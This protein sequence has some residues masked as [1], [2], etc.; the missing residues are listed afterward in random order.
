MIGRLVTFAVERRW[1]VL[2]FTGIA[3]LVGALALQRLPI[4]AV[5]DITNNQVQV[6]V[7]AAVAVAR[8][9]RA[10]SIVYDRNLARRY[11]WPRIHALA[12]P[13]RLCA[14]HGRI[15]RQRPI[16]TLPANRW[17]NGCVGPKNVCRKGIMPEMGPIATGLGDIFMWTVELR[18]LDKVRH[19]D[20][21]PGLQRDGSYITPEGEHLVSE[22]DKA[23][24][25]H[26]V[27]E[28]IVA[29]QLRG[30]AG[31]AGID[32]LGGFDRQYLVMPDLQR[33]AALRLTIQDLAT[34][35]W[36]AAIAASAR[37][38]WT[39]TAK[40]LFVRSDARVRTANELART[41]VATRENVPI[42][43]DQVATVKARAWHPH[44]LRFR[45]R[46]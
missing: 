30:T 33:L 21:E 19:R 1:L 34:S 18:E 5:P 25:L 39:A 32:S 7:M 8:S 20:G 41:V 17:P 13:E 3:A 43:L 24:Y 23:T 10:A 26:T 28:W 22:E 11:S 44:R 2:L 38:S 31:V 9:D 4:D 29:P 15:F 37:A 42:T 36:S 6:N 35:H 12:Q 40:G 46:P 14:N 45:K 27:Q 16:S